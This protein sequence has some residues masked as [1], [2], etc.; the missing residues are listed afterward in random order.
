MDR[1]CGKRGRDGKYMLYK[2]LVGKPEGKRPLG[3]SRRRRQYNIKVDLKKYSVRMWAGFI[4]LRIGCS[5]C[6]CRFH[7]RRTI[8]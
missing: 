5:G 4:W 6:H 8:S 1:V 7:T 2:T 3:K